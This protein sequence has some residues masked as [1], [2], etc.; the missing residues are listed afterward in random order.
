MAHGCSHLL[1]GLQS[2]PPSPSLCSLPPP[3][4]T[5]AALQRAP[6][7]IL[8]PQALPQLSWLFLSFI[9]S[10]QISF[11]CQD[12]SAM[13]L[14]LPAPHRGFPW[15]LPTVLP[16]CLQARDF[17]RLLH[18]RVLPPQ[19]LMII[20]TNSWF[21]LVEK[22]RIRENQIIFASLVLAMHLTDLK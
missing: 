13:G 6:W 16:V 5:R 7:H 9:H 4:H 18:L 1:P 19:T 20:D 17:S 2:P 3:P 14:L 22:P 10:V 21:F 12:G 15:L 8:C 11:E